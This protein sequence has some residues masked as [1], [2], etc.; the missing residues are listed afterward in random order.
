[1]KFKVQSS[2]FK[3]NC[4]TEGFTLIELLIIFATTAIISTIGVA[5]FVTYS[6]LQSVINA[7]L[8]IKA[9]LEQARNQTSSQVNH[10][11]SC[12]TGQCSC[13]SGQTFGGYQ[14]LFCCAAG[15]AKPLCPQNCIAGDTQEHY[16]MDIICGGNSYAVQSKRFPTNVSIDDNNSS[17]RSFLFWPITGMIS[18]SGKVVVTGY[19]SS[20]SVSVSNIGVIQ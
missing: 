15:N 18:G 9:M 19:G 16:E 2:K 6:H 14:V 7:Q 3:V 11:S 1:M 12:L 17:S 4:K 10:P 5:S 20:R 8:D 13:A